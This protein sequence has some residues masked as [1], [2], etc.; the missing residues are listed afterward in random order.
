VAAHDSR[1][2]V[3]IDCELPDIESEVAAAERRSGLSVN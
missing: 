1:K 2:A 3:L